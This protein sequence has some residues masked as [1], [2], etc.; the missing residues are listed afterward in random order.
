MKKTVRLLALVAISASVTGCETV[1]IPDTDTYYYD[2]SD[3]NVVTTNRYHT[4]YPY[5]VNFIY[6]TYPVYSYPYYRYNHYPYYWNN[7]VYYHNYHG[8]RGGYHAGFYGR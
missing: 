7:G 3:V 6:S 1:Y 5:D 4:D 8:Y 2:S